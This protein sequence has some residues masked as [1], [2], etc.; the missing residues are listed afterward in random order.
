MAKFSI[1]KDAKELS[2]LIDKPGTLDYS[3]ESNNLAKKLYILKQFVMY[4]SHFRLRAHVQVFGKI[5]VLRNCQ[6]YQLYI[7]I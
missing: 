3:E 7:G 4:W 6:L 1:S 2:I 5:Y